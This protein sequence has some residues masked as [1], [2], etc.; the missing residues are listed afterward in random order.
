MDI[1]ETDFRKVLESFTPVS[2]KEFKRFADVM[3]ERHLNRGEVLLE[4]GQVCREFYFI[5]S[6]YMRSF[7]LENGEE[8]NV[9]FYF[10][11][12]FASDFESFK[13]ATPSKYY[14]V[15]MEDTIFFYGVKTKVIPVLESDIS[16]YSFVFRFFQSLYFRETE[17]SDS[18]KLM[19]PQERYEFLVK[20][21]PGYLQRIPLIY[22]ASY[23][24]IRRKTLN[25]VREKE[26]L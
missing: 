6:G 26:S 17:H 4:E 19:S 9:K 22:F 8:I 25:R 18:F 7:I 20:H 16:L 1:Y 24:G 12:D 3:H 14:L 10:E 5:V 21:K 11:N 2:D 13:N 15:A 23:L